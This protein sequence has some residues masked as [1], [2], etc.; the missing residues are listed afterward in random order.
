MGLKATLGNL[1]TILYNCALLW[2]FW[3][4]FSGELSSQNDDNRRQLWTIVGKCLK[5]PF[6]KPPFKL[7]RERADY[8]YII[9]STVPV[10]IQ[11]QS[12][13]PQSSHFVSLSCPNTS[14]RSVLLI[15][16]L[17]TLPALLNGQVLQEDLSLISPFGG[18]AS[19]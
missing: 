7:S 8:L 10:F 16:E 1:R 18:T 5:P 15:H 13:A 9:R 12:T 11:L 4:A 17:A 19:S 6:A 2:P 3:A 14:P